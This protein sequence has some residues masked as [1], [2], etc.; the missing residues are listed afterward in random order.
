MSAYAIAYLDEMNV[1]REIVTYL[2]KIDDTLKPYDGRFLVHGKDS[3]VVEGDFDGYCIIIEFPDMEQ[4]RG[5]YYSDAYQNIAD[6][7]INNCEGSVILVKGV[8]GNYQAADLLSN[9]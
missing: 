1:N 6:L 5:W 4:A 7:R 9:G 3:E 8:P 2:S